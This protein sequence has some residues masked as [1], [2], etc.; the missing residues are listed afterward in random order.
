MRKRG[1]PVP[2]T[3]KAAGERS[4]AQKE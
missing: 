4:G 1:F 3:A 2:A